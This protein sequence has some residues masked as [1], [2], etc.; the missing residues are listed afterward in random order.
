MRFA[1]GTLNGDKTQIVT[2]TPSAY[3]IQSRNWGLD[4]RGNQLSVT[5]RINNSQTVDTKQ[6]NEVNEYTQLVWGGGSPITPT[7]DNSGN[8]LSDGTKNFVYDEENRL[9]QVYEGATLKLQ[10][11][12]DALSNRVVTSHGS[13]ITLQVSVGGPGTL[14]ERSAD[15]TLQREFVYGHDFLEPVVMVDHTSAGA[16]PAGQSE[17]LYYL[18]DMLRSVVALTDSTGTVVEKYK[19]EPYGATYI[20]AP[21]GERRT[22]S[23]Y[24]NAVLWTG[25]HYDPTTNLYLYQFRAYSPTLGRFLQRDPIGYVGGMNLYEYV[26]SSAVGYFDPL[27]LKS[28]CSE[29]DQN[30][31]NAVL[32][33]V[34]ADLAYQASLKDWEDAKKQEQYSKNKMQ[35]DLRIYRHA[36]DRIA[37]AEDELAKEVG[38]DATNDILAGMSISVGVA[39]VKGIK[40]IYEGGKLIIKA[41]VFSVAGVVQT[42]IVWYWSREMSKAQ[43]LKVMAITSSIAAD[44]KLLAAAQLALVNDKTQYNAAVQRRKKATNQMIKVWQN[45]CNALHDMQ[46]ACGQTNGGDRCEGDSPNNSQHG[47]TNHD[48][49]SGERNH[50]H[51]NQGHDNDVKDKV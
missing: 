48:P 39:S 18:Q 43:A 37:K 32:N 5:S 16:L 30:C 24:G 7:H 17:P 45:R 6:V 40:M 35:I 1:R 12:Y 25:Q 19:Y 33:F 47:N 36:K 11:A 8:L 44:Y 21:N 3:L 34:L 26:G 51:G 46:N 14:E 13:E 27:G 23:S 9:T 28:N 29:N 38:W 42:V 10:A 2:P 20:L 15:G 31:L 49:G 22:T 41:S 4:H 50:G